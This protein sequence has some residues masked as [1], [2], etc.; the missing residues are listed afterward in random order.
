[1]LCSIVWIVS[2]ASSARVL[3]DSVGFNSRSIYIYILYIIKRERESVCV[4]EREKERQTE[5]AGPEGQP[6]GKCQGGA[7]HKD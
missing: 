1:M 6:G 2:N 5:I 7:G 4:R 3:V